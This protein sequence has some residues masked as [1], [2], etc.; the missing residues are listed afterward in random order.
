MMTRTVCHL[1][2]LAV[3]T[4][5]VIT[6]HVETLVVQVSQI[7]ADGVTQGEFSVADP[8]AAGRAVID[9]TARFHNPLH[10][11]EWREPGID[12]AFQ[13]VWSLVH[14]LGVQGASL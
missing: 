5:E 6:A 4:R 2:S 1:L 11:T 14:G 8:L 13:A 9:A 7:I 3:E 10:A 12:A